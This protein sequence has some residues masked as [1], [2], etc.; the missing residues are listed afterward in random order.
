[1]YSISSLAHLAGQGT[2]SM[3]DITIVVALGAFYVALVYEAVRARNPKYIV[4][5]VLS[6]VGIVFWFFT[7]V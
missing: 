3:P 4:L 1:M 6:T 2:N 5:S 7:W